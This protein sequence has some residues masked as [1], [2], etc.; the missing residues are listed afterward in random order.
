LGRY[1]KAAIG[2]MHVSE[3]V[4]VKY[5]LQKRREKRAQMVALETAKREE[6]ILQY[7]TYLYMDFFLNA[8]SKGQLFDQSQAEQRSLQRAR[9]VLQVIYAHTHRHTHI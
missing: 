4:A 1:A 9:Y 7:A 5:W 6:R 2:D 3:D 8:Q